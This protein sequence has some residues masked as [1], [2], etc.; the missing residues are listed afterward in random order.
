MNLTINSLIKTGIIWVV[1]NLKSYPSSNIFIANSLI[2]LSK[3]ETGILNLFFKTNKGVEY[4]DSGTYSSGIIGG[5]I[6]DTAY[7]TGKLYAVKL[8]SATTATNH[9]VQFKNSSN[10]WK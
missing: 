3:F 8:A 7:T 5:T 9:S 1:W 2:D 4:I 10:K 6:S